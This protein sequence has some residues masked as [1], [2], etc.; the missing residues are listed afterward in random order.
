MSSIND[1]SEEIIELTRFVRVAWSGIS[2][3]SVARDMQQSIAK[4]RGKDSSEATV[5]AK[6][7]SDLLTDVES[8]S[9]TQTKLGFPYLYGLAAI[10]VWSILEA[11][12]QDLVRECLIE[13]ERARSTEPVRKIKGPL[14]EF[15]TASPSMQAEFLVNQLANDLGSKLKKGVGRFESLLG[16]INLGGNVHETV[17][18]Q[19]FELSELRNA[20]VHR[21]SLADTRVVAACPWLKLNVGDKIQIT[22]K[23]FQSYSL[24][25][26]WYM[27]ELAL[28]EHQTYSLDPTPDTGTDRIRAI[29]EKLLEE[30]KTH[31]AQA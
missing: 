5:Q 12:I 22:P 13:H 27:C 6:S 28:R 21:S 3:M 9:E 24:A 31:V 20:I 19:I 8:F 10:R 7:E 18:K 16:A 17:A 2:Y 14:L 1:A 15:S 26:R 11:M 30:L 23:Q 29:R 4:I 25:A